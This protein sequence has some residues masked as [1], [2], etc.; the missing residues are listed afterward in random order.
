[1]ACDGLGVVPQ[2]AARHCV[3]ALERAKLLTNPLGVQYECWECGNLV[4]TLLVVL[5]VLVLLL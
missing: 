3:N 2:S 4:R 5:L 1:M